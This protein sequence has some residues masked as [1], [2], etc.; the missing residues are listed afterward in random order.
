MDYF[1]GVRTDEVKKLGTKGVYYA[2]IAGFS[3]YFV[4]AAIETKTE[5]E[6]E[7]WGLTMVHLQFTWGK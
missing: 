7:A 2:A 6:C 1:L 4:D 3:W 5:V